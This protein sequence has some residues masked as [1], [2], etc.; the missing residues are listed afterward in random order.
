[1]FCAGIAQANPAHWDLPALMRLLAQHPSGKVQFTETKSLAVLDKPVISKGELIYRAP[2][3]LEKHTL[4]P[5][6]ES[7]VI[8]GNTLT[9]ERDGK[10]R[11]LR[12]P[13]YPEILAFVE[14][15]RGTLIGNQALL[16]QHYS[17]ALS[18]TERDWRLT[19]KPLD[20]SMLRWVKQINVSGAS[21]AVTAV[22]T[23]QADG[24]KSLIAI[25]TGPR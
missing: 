7:M 3:R 21:N 5:K 11:Q 15:L 12:L 6:P 4:K 16:E 10:Q 9:V 13:Q 8:E 23:L 19:L 25:T 22:E 1:M 24:D 17:V 14:A 2:D 20:Q 18:G